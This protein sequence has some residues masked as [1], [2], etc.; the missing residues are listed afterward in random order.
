M[1][2]DNKLKNKVGEIGEGMLINALGGYGRFVDAEGYDVETVY[3]GN[4]IRIES[5][6]ARSIYFDEGQWTF[7]LSNP[8]M[9]MIKRRKLDAVWLVCLTEKMNE[10]LTFLIPSAE[11]KFKKDGLIII[12][13]NNINKQDYAKWIVKDEDQ[14]KEVLRGINKKKH[15]S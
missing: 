6:C 9:R 13:I 8:Q 5:K 2:T 10:F 7:H 3:Q 4:L 1:I 15:Q 12:R 11:L 14:V